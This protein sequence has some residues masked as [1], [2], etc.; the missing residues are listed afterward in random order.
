[1]PGS[2]NRRNGTAG[3]MGDMLG[4]LADPGGAYAAVAKSANSTNEERR[5]HDRFRTEKLVELVLG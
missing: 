3:A 1:M 4:V 2:I 5:R